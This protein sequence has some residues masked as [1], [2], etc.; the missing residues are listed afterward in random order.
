MMLSLYD[1]GGTDTFD[2]SALAPDAFGYHINLTEGGFI[3]TQSA[4]NASSYQAVGDTSGAYYQTT[5][6]GI[7]LAYNPLLSPY[8][9]SSF[10]TL[11]ENLVNSSSNDLIIANSAANKFGGYN[12]GR[13]V[14]SD[15]IQGTNA[16]D[17]LDLAGY[18]G[19]SITQTQSGNNLVLGLGSNG[20]V[21]I[22]DYYLA[23]SS[24]RINLLFGITPAPTISISDVTV[25]EGLTNPTLA[26]FAVALSSSSTQTVTVNYATIALTATAGVDYSNTTATLTFAPGETV[27][28]VNVPII[29]DNLNEVDETFR[30]KLSNPT[31][32]TVAVF[33][34]TGTIT[35]TLQ[36]SVT[37]TLPAGVENLTLT[38]TANINGTG[39]KGNNILTGNS[40]NNVLNGGLGNDTMYGGLG[41]D[42]Y[43]VNAVGDQ[44]IEE[45]TLATE[46][47]SVTSWVNFTLGNNVENL[48]LSGT[49]TTGIGNA[50]NN[51]ITGN[52]SA[53]TLIGNA[54]ND[55]LDGKA[56]NDILDGGAGDDTY[57]VDNIGDQIIDSSGNDTVKSYISWTLVDGLENLTLLGSNP[58]AGTGNNANNL[59]IGNSAANTL[60]GGAGNDTLDGKGGADNLNG[61]DGYDTYYIDNIGDSISD[62][63][64]VDI[65]YSTVSFTLPSTVENLILQ[66]T[67]GI[68]GTGNAADNLLTGNN[69]ANTLTGGDGVDTITGLGGN[70]ILVAGFGDDVLTGGTGADKFRFNA[71][72]EGIDIIEDFKNLAT[73]KDFIQISAAGF[74]G[75]LTA[76]AL[77]ATK[78][79][80]AAG[81]T[82]PTNSTQRFI[83]N[84]SNGDLFYDADGLAGGTIQIASLF[85]APL[86]NNTNIA[87][88]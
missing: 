26:A 73:E 7:A 47:D 48:T 43:I 57:F 80:S 6:L 64:G 10:N 83:Y 51:T 46:I 39:N 11:I 8:N 14:G 21:T 67:S 32:A 69:G 42:T 40:G 75:G 85:G 87:V 33:S 37:K 49:A 3:T 18:S 45:S 35:D 9:S 36:A 59:L 71:T 15:I 82:T 44:V 12:A 66:G 65:V 28:T 31:N 53:N 72:N 22:T 68:S 20:S 74:G 16:Q 19:S 25:V 24:D 62:S 61:G 79:L 4:Y 76:G 55:I 60:S 5:T 2:F 84:S 77:A 27:K 23:P 88:I 52:S 29:N 56:G 30:V 13:V 41:N 34:A 70:D 1:A 58:I 63:S 17:I 86:I 81:A 54:G 78:F 50:L 38:G